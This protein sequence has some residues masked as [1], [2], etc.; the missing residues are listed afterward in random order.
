[1]RSLIR[2]L[3]AF[4]RRDRLDDELA[5]KIRTHIELR[6]RALIE[7]GWPPREAAAE[8]R[9]QFGNVTAVREQSRDHWG[10]ALLTAS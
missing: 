1:M 4:L 7:Q 10:S 5:E 2:R 8:A 9:R 6:W 3:L